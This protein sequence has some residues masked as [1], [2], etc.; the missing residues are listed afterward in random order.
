MLNAQRVGPRATTR[1]A[2]HPCSRCRNGPPAS[3]CATSIS[4]Q[5]I[6]PNLVP[7]AF[8]TASL[9]QRAPATLPVYLSHVIGL[10]AKRIRQQDWVGQAQELAASQATS[11]RSADEAAAYGRQHYASFTMQLLLDEANEVRRTRVTHIQSGQS[12][13]WSG[14]YPAYLMDFVVQHAELRIETSEPA[15]P[16]DF[17]PVSLAS[18]CGGRTGFP[19]RTGGPPVRG[20][21]HARVHHVAIGG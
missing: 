5:P 17:E 19:L 12:G 9:A 1:L 21:T 18:C 8:V 11:E 3:S 14:W 7:R 10:T 16:P 2:A 6:G 15:M 13:I 20:C 4:S